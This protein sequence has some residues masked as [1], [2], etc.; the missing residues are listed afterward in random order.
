MI[1]CLKRALLA[2]SFPRE[3]HSIL[4]HWQ[5]CLVISSQHVWDRWHK[6]RAEY[7]GITR[8][9][10]KE[11]GK[12]RHLATRTTERY[13]PWLS[14]NPATLPWASSLTFCMAIKKR[15][16]NHKQVT[17]QNV[18]SP[19]IM[20]RNIGYRG[21]QA[22]L[23]AQSASHWGFLA[24]NSPSQAPRTTGRTAACLKVR[25]IIKSCNRNRS[26]NL[27]N[28]CLLHS[29]P[30]QSLSMETVYFKV[31]QFCTCLSC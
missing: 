13:W 22:A 15:E 31:I 30:G 10:P 17:M 21:V 20:L 16:N 9:L 19:S 25:A 27:A 2:T 18:S 14:C 5:A 7:R 3:G 29:F 23:K 1:L 26:L 8:I 11:E 24:D 28:K 4:K 12:L 6:S